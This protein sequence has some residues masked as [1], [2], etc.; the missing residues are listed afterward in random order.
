MIRFLIAA[1]M[2]LTFA[3]KQEPAPIE[4]TETPP[5]D[6]PYFPVYAF[7]KGEQ[8]FVDSL[9]GGIRQIIIRNGQRDSSYISLEEFH[10]WSDTFLS[11]ELLEE[12]FKNTF[13]EESFFDQ[14]QKS[15]NF[16]YTPKDGNTTVKRVDITT[17]TKDIYDRVV[18]L[19]IEKQVST[20]KGIVTQKLLWSPGKQFQLI[21]IPDDGNSDRDEF[22]VRV[23]WDNFEEAQ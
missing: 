6:Q 20:E 8:N 12:N 1:V 18:S 13:K 15:S 2:L 10:R 7:L 23:I 9:P 16:L 19:Y 3:C 5:A 11:T 22:E 14:T 17:Q 21:N 4:T